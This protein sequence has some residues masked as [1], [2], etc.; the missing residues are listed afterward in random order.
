MFSDVKFACILDSFGDVSNIVLI[1]KE[2]KDELRFLE[3][4]ALSEKELNVLN[5]IID[6]NKDV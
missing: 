3:K 2:V 1:G 6:G 4:F 5:L